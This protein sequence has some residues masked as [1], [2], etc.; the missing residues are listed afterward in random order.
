MGSDSEYLRP[1]FATPEQALD[2]V[3]CRFASARHQGKQTL[4]ASGLD[5]SSVATHS[6]QKTATK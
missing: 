3:D 1:L 6:S 2:F 4:R 5:I